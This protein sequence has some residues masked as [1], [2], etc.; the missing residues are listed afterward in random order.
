[1]LQR[2]IKFN[3]FILALLTAI[4]VAYV[5]P[6]GANFLHL[7]QVTDVG[8]GLIFFFYGLKL[9]MHTFRAGVS[10]YKLHLL[11]HL[12]TFIIF[13]LLVLPFKSLM[14]SESAELLWVG[15]FFLSVLPSTVSSSVVMVSIA[16]GNI[17]AAIFNA[18]LSGLLGVALTPLWLGLLVDDAQ[19]VSAL[20][21]IS[22]LMLQIVLPLTL[23]ILL[24]GQFGQLALKNSTLIANF[25]KTI[26]VL[27]VYTSFCLSFL[28]NLF[29]GL[30]ITVLFMLCLAILALFFF[31]LLLINAISNKLGFSTEDRITAIFC[32]SKKSL[33]HGSVMAKIMF[34]HSANASIYILPV[35]LY[36]ISQL[37]IVAY[38]AQKLG[39]RCLKPA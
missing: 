27:I 24:H 33:V 37:L 22:K 38:I 30:N 7:N 5:W 35:M 23:G 29:S 11:I 4:P 39:K 6:T 26:I 32:G 17:P 20:S 8:I 28:A 14:V 21:V 2:K 34:G 3:G 12:S 31:M 1:M 9:S 13:P 16:K 25:D 18:S 10:N 36:H 15:M 19:G